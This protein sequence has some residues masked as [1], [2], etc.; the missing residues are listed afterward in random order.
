MQER[1]AVQAVWAG[2]DIPAKPA[3]VVVVVKPNVNFYACV[4][5]GHSTAATA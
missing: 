1:W 4:T 3:K 2:V 5:A